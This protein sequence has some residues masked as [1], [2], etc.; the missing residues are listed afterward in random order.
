MSVLRHKQSG[1]PTVWSSTATIRRT[2]PFFSWTHECAMLVQILICGGNR[3][4][5]QVKNGDTV[6]IH[7]TGTFENGEIF[8]TAI[9]SDPLQFLVG[10]GEVIVGFDEGVLEMEIGEKKRIEIEPENAYGERRDELVQI[11]ARTGLNLEEN[12]VCGMSL[13]MHLPDGNEI[14]VLITDVNS[15]TITLDAN[16][17]LAGQKLIFHVERVG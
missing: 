16:H 10:A 4:S 13:S 1:Q 12:P 14:P 9:G 15:E 6:R 17:P 8:D 2:S 3:L 11:V 5:S 7:Y